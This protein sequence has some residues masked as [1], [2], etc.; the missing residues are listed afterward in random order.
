[1]CVEQLGLL[2]QDCNKIIALSRDRLLASSQLAPSDTTRV[3]L[4]RVSML[5]LEL[6]SL[7]F[8]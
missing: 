4:R 5:A 8:L 2:S 6:N 3:E 7:V 1:M